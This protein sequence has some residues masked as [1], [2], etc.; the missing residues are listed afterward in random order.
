MNIEAK[1]INCELLKRF[2][3]RPEVWNEIGAGV[4]QDL[5]EEDEAEL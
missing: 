2:F 1:K 4:W 5:S 3:D